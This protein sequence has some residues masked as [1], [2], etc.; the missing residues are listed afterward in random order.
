MLQPCVS[1]NKVNTYQWYKQRVYKLADNYD[2]SDYNK[3]LKKANEWGEQIPIGIF[4]QKEKKIFRDRF[5]QLDD[6][7]LVEKEINP[8][9]VKPF[10]LDFK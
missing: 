8:L 10:L 9:R 2:D 6:R 1:F 3:A 5:S 4:Y 7:P